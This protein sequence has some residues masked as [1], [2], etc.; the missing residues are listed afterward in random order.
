MNSGMVKTTI[1]EIRESFGRYMAILAIV[2]LGVGLFAG[3]KATT[4]AMI[5]TEN[6]YL[7]EQ[8][9]FDFRLLSTIGFTE[10]NVSELKSFDEAA[11]VEGTISVDAICTFGEGNESAYKIHAM[12]E[13]INRIV[14]TA[15]RMPE[16]ADECVLDDALYGEEI[17]GSRITVTDNNEE[18]TLEMFRGRSFTVVGLARSPL[19][20]NS[21]RGTTSIGSGRIT[22]FLYVPKEAFDC[23]YLTEI[24]ITAKEKYDV[25]TEEYQAYTDVLEESVEEV[26]EAIVQNRY[27]ELIAEA[28]EKIDD[29]QKEL[30]EKKAEAE[31][32]LNDALVKIQDGEQELIDGEQELLDG[33]QKIADG[34]QEIADYE[35]EIADGEQE[36]I[37]GEQEIQDK[38]LEIQD[39]E[40]ELSGHEWEIF[41][42]EIKL[43]N[44]RDELASAKETLQEK[45]SLLL[46]KEEEALSQEAELNVQASELSAQLDGLAVQEAELSAQRETL[47]AQDAE[48][49][50]Q[51]TALN[52]QKEGL[53]LSLATGG[54]TKDEYDAAMIQVDAG[55]GQVQASRS[56][57][58]TG[59]GQIDAGLGE[60]QSG[61]TQLQ[62]GLGQIQTGL[63]QI[64]SGKAEIQA[65]KEQ[66]GVAKDE[67]EY[68]EKVLLEAEE[69]LAAAKTEITNA[70]TELEDG[71][72]KLADA[73]TELEEGK[74]ELE[75]GKAEL[76]KAR[77]ELADAQTE[78]EEGKTE[79]ED[80]RAELADART[81]Y[82]DAK[83]EFETEVADAQ[84]KI[85]DARAELADIE[86][87]DYYVLNRNTNIG[88]ACY[89]SDSNIVAAIANVFPLFFF[90]VAALICMTTMNRMV[91]EQRT[92]IGVLKALGYG[93]AAIMGKFLF[94]AGS[95]AAIGTLIGLVGGTWL[96]PR[97]IWT[98]YGIIYNMGNIEYYFGVP[99]AVLSLAAALLCSMG[100]AYASCRYELYSVPASLIRPKAPKSGKRIFLERVTFL[101]RRLKFLQKVS[102]RNLI[103][104]KKRFFMMILGISGCTALLVTGFG[105]K[106][107]VADIAGMQYDKI[108][109]F[110]I[111][112]TFAD[113]VQGTDMDALAEQTG[114]KL[115]QT[116]CRYEE[117]VDLDFGG[118][119]KSTYL[120]IPENVEEI[121]VFLNLHT[122]DGEPIPYPA[123]GE[124]ILSA[125]L[126][127]NLG[128]KA[129]DKVTLRDNDMNS[130]EVTV[131]AL[132]E[133]FVY[134]YVYICKETYMEQIGKEPEYRS[135]YAI[136]RE[137]MDI[138]EAAAAI[139][140]QDNVLAVSVTQDMR[141]RIGTMMKSMDYIVF[142]IIF[143]AGSLAFIV[144]YNLTNINITER[145]RE[146]ATIKVLGF[147]A[148]ETADY[149]FR[150]NL[151][152]TGMGAVVGLGLGKLLHWF[153]M[154]NINLDMVSFKT[155]IK[156]VS[157]VWSLVL[158]FV[159]A[160]FVNGL[161]FFKLEKINM[162]ESLKS[163]E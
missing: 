63:E 23:D 17:I 152:L 146:I 100:A 16:S 150:E 14:L 162:A 49:A 62:E 109:I 78:L 149:V 7:A 57:I 114:G 151:F 56:E 18:D 31:E 36:L 107:S 20:I 75:D 52:E 160:M 74:T 65:G 126:A 96:F 122:P 15:G 102:V 39:A 76:A 141:E 30:D 137:D 147:Y 139:S 138:H 98:G 48:L 3:L 32:E 45:E 40:T 112:I 108:Q 84:E 90:L 6:A 68:Q 92:Q 156:P 157:Y 53:E 124:A 70:R 19:Y 38:E 22:A 140:D 11:D 35:Q 69:E 77:T 106:D 8:N 142:L 5:A 85:D 99:V 27:D 21:E 130:L 101:W 87:P 86:E 119:T 28:Q 88:Y 58:Q 51:E 135:A 120:V 25:Y 155:L 132:C 37:D 64:A 116:A 148:K 34:T 93:N 61:R 161:M 163:I 125:K 127:E 144:L 59:I 46:A 33:E 55:L 89:E 123:D 118:R 117:S 83:A 113:G 110:D 104:Y 154:Y 129:G 158:T 111:G 24:Y 133:N 80:G 79:L 47:A 9:F 50:A 136:V 42:N 82:D 159:F 73:K 44:G 97:V 81:E 13:K 91:E 2:M 71:K 94:Y 115:E 67:I 105:V 26:T 128:I 143:C 121:T 41:E 54:I 60:I 12:P 145:I 66:I 1:R 103:R 72:I 95:A 131:S 10:E 153:V 43:S 134:S 29:A 4:P